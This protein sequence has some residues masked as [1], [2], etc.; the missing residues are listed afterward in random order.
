MDSDQLAELS[1]QGGMD[2]LVLNN[3][4]LRTVG[5]NMKSVLRGVQWS[6]WIPVPFGYGGPWGESSHCLADWRKTDSHIHLVNAL[7]YMFLAT[8]M[9]DNGTPR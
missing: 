3:E 4:W 9:N 8:A 1:R 7:Q 2:H 6:A 5:K